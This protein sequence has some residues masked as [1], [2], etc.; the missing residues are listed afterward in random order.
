MSLLHLAWTYFR[1]RALLT[2]SALGIALGV[3]LVFTTLAVVN[4]FLSELERTLRE[5]SGD[6]VV[7]PL[8]IGPLA[9]G[10]AEYMR[11]L[12]AVD[13]LESATPRLNWFGLVGRRGARALSDPRSADLN[14]LLLVGVEPERERAA[15]L[16]AELL[17]QPGSLILGDELAQRLGVAAGDALEVLSYRGSG[18]DLAPVRATFQVAGSFRTGQYEQDLDR[19]I[20]RR[21][22]LERFLGGRVP[23]TEIV[24]RGARDI[25]PEQLAARAR[26]ALAEA[27]IRGADVRTWRAQGGNLLAAV[28][29]QRGTLSVVFFAIVAVAAFQLLAT[30]TLTVTEK[31]HDIGVLGA[32]GAGPARVAGFFMVLCL[33]I[34]AAGTALGLALGLWLCRNLHVVELWIGGGER[35]FTPELYQFPEIPI[36]VDPGSVSVLVGATLAA[37][38]LFSCIPAWLAARLPIV[39]ALHH[40]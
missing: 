26:M 37:A 24:L 8:E 38:L 14:G 31:R 29:N 17:A 18:R 13:G 28:E 32:L 19:A 1:R 39:R 30:L 12:E 6:V 34:G 15:A 7:R 23:F 22:D 5:F 25:A 36:A 10:R 9:A 33:V 40:A 2:L 11:A 4:G 21:E 16:H 3:A 35:I 20:V 27:G